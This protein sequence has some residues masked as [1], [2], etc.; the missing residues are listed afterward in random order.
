MYNTMLDN[1]YNLNSP[2][3]LKKSSCLKILKMKGWVKT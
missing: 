2:P 3:C 1:T